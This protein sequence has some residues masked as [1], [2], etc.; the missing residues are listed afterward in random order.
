MKDLALN[1]RDLMS[2]GYVGPAIGKRLNQLLQLVVDEEIPNTRDAL[3][4]AIP[5]LEENP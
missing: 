3:L 5:H 4:A 2:M 1:G